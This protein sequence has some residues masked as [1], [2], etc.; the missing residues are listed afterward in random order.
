[1]D[2]V[3]ETTQLAWSSSLVVET[4]QKKRMTRLA[5]GGILHLDDK[6]Y[7]TTGSITKYR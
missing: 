4:Q 1:M 6:I 2:E 3:E 5:M 7:S